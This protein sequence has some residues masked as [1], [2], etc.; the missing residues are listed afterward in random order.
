[1]YNKEQ[2]FDQIKFIAGGASQHDI[3]EIES[4]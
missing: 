1:M 3:M 4:Y 2:D